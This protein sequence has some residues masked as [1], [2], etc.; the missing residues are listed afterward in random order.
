MRR[1]R[2]GQLD[3]RGVRLPVEDVREAGAM[4]AHQH[5]RPL[6]QLELIRKELY[7][8]LEERRLLGRG[9]RRERRA[10]K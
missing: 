9:A 2:V 4:R 8:G 3:D 1:R 5:V 7:L 6:H 10:P